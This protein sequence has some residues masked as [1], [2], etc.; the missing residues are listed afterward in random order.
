MQQAVREVASS[1]PVAA[2]FANWERGGGGPQAV[3]RGES[4]PKMIQQIKHKVYKR[5]CLIR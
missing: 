5:I 3:R 2:F 4:F 1:L